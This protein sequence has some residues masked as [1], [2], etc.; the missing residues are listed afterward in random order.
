MINNLFSSSPRFLL[1]IFLLP[2]FI[3]KGMELDHYNFG[4]KQLV[5]GVEEIDNNF[6]MLAQFPPELLHK[7]IMLLPKDDLGFNYVRQYYK[8]LYKV[9]PIEFAEPDV[10]KFWNRLILFSNNIGELEQKVLR[11]H[12]ILDR[13]FLN[14]EVLN[15]AYSTLVI[16]RLLELNKK[17]KTLFESLDLDIEQEYWQG[18][19]NKI[20][21]LGP[22]SLLLDDYSENKLEALKSNML[23]LQGV[24]RD[25]IGNF[26]KYIIR[27]P[28][29]RNKFMLFLVGMSLVGTVGSLGCSSFATLETTSVVL[30][31]LFIIHNNLF[32]YVVVKN[33]II[34]SIRRRTLLKIDLVLTEIDKAIEQIKNQ[35][36]KD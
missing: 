27:G 5:T 16:T 1:I 30:L 20:C 24:K 15:Q 18:F 25:L 4:S 31:L 9:I 32:S 21:L 11:K 14:Y 10:G 17:R 29:K 26:P 35:K 28:V 34:D 12:Q 23:V 19:R 8:M 22:Q 36:T 33:L 2:Q 3:S 13:A 7:I 6:S